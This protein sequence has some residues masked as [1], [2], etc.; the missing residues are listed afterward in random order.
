MKKDLKVAIW[1]VTYN[2]EAYIDQAITSVMMQETTF[3]YH[4][5]IGED[6]STDQT[7]RLC[8]SLKERYPNNIT[9]VL[10]K[11]NLGS[12]A[13]AFQM[14]DICLQS[15]AI[16][17]AMLEGDDYWTDP[18]KLQ[19]QVDYLDAH[20]EVVFSFT[21]FSTLQKGLSLK[22]N[23]AHFFKTQDDL[24][25]DFEMFTKGWYGGTLTLVFRSSAIIIDTI[26]KY[27]YFRDV[28]LYTE[29]LKV[30]NGVC[31]N[32]DSAVYRTHALG[33][34]TS[35]SELKR[36]YTAVQCYSELYTK[37]S[38]ILALKTKYYYFIKR[39]IKLLINKEYNF[40]AL[41]VILSFTFKMKDLEFAKTML[42]KMMKSNRFTTY[43]KRLLKK[44]K[45]KKPFEGSE[46]YWEQRYQS[47]K[48]SGAGSYGRLADFK[49]EVLNQFVNTHSID[50]VIEYGSGDGNQLK[51]AKYPNYVGFDVSEK[52][53]AICRN[54]FKNDSSKAFYSVF[55]A[56]YTHLK[57]DLVLSLDVIYHLVE[58]VVFDSYMERLFKTSKRYV[59]IYSSNYDKV[60]A[61]HVKCRKFTDWIEMHKAT[62]WKQMDYIP[63][64]YP[65]DEHNPNHT[66]MADFYIYEKLR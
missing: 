38:S 33:I 63:N 62:T 2:H 32:F 23:N 16:Y 61:P 54:L 31:L 40:K 18:L 51:L 34:H 43:L 21:R 58:D 11:T 7:F 19:K 52:A 14:Y 47:N 42:K 4:L 49:A 10:N 44:K 27:Q 25:F 12:T 29:L 64:R 59:I 57:A 50:T 6:C 48:D 8:K 37:N 22:D 35:A 60:L 3:T 5:Y 53:L 45:R 46:Q 20:P 55:D 41:M 56:N 36:A 1:M 26:N 17:I 9:L 66:S 13:N 30:G 15:G 28:Y 65:F 39:Y 24:V